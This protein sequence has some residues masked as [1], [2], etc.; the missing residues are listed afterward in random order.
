MGCGD[1]GCVEMHPG[2]SV[3]IRESMWKGMGGCMC[4]WCRV[5][6]LMFLY[7]RMCVGRC[8]STW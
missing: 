8:T 7:G 5:Q 2:I 4:V 6:E 3:I 1:V